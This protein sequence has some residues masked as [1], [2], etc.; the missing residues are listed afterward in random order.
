[1]AHQPSVT[2]LNDACE[3]RQDKLPTEDQWKPAVERAATLFG[4]AVSSL[5]NASNVQA[6]DQ[7]V[8]QAAGRLRQPCAGYVKRLNEVLVA[9]GIAVSESLRLTTARATQALLERLAERQEV[10]VVALLANADVP[11]TLQAMGEC[12]AGAAVL[13]QTL[14]QASWDIF[15]AVGKLNDDRQQAGTLILDS[16][17]Q[18]LNSDEHVIALGPC[19]VDERGKGVRLL[20][21]T[22][23][24][25]R[26]VPPPVT[27]PIRPD[28]QPDVRVVKHDSKDFTTVEDAQQQLNQIKEQLT[29][30]QKL[31][32]TLTWRIESHESK[33]D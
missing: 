9:Q 32:L 19:L 20:T 30:G 14:A 26:I 3:L 4:V 2:D 24:E 15:E 7:Q 31:T 8:K 22:Q 17:K 18:A 29:E 25:Q 13:D 33:K 5:R 10:D 16:V 1:M 27:D 23:P 21:V 11:T 12:A 6:L 28:P